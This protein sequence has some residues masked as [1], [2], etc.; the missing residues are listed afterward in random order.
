MADLPYIKFYPG[1]WERDSNCLTA[2]T[3]FA[4]FKLIPKFNDAKNKGVFVAHL[5]ALCV[6]F[7]SDLTTT[8]RVITELKR[9]NTVDISELEDECFEF[10][11][12]R[13]LREAAISEIRSEVGKTGGRGHKKA[14][15]KLIKTKAK[16]KPKLNHEYEHDI[17]SVVEYL[18]IKASTDFKVSKAATQTLIIARRKE[19]YTV[20]QFKTVIDKKTSEWLTNPDM[21]K[22]LRPETL[23]GSK[24]EGYLN[25]VIIPKATLPIPDAKA[26]KAEMAITSDESYINRKYGSAIN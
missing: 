7:K 6:L 10:K 23:F 1:D 14:N 18:N 13:V 2:I 4:L 17:E 24:F 12:R 19:G 21:I 20:D 15:E 8:K 11:N 3:E 25:Q 5:D 9:N 16:P 26:S 22:Y